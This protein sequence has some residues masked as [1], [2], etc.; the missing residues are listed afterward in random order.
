MFFSTSWWSG[1][2]D[3]KIKAKS[4]FIFS[5]LTTLKIYR[6][7]HLTVEQ[8]DLHA[9]SYC[10]NCT[11]GSFILPL[12]MRIILLLSSSK[13]S[14]QGRGIF[15]L[16]NQADSGIKQLCA[17]LQRLAPWRFG[18]WGRETAAASGFFVRCLTVFPYNPREVTVGVFPCS[19]ESWPSVCA[20]Q[21]RPR[22]FDDAK[23]NANV[24][25]KGM[26]LNR[27]QPEVGH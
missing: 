13:E 8:K 5:T 10:L 15:F 20:N 22:A 27:E 26:A 17:Q 19:R 3:L 6:K 25:L 9:F 16:H 24:S 1:L 21:G 14:F 2:L 11:R 12:F 18:Y 4:L 23:W 7:S